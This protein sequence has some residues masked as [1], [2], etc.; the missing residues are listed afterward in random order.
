M[1]LMLLFFYPSIVGNIQLPLI[2]S[3]NLFFWIQIYDLDSMILLIVTTE[4]LYTE[5]DSSLY[6]INYPPLRIFVSFYS[7]NKKNL[8]ASS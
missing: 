3:K 8:S 4:L 1:L 7:S 6:F 2:S 5:Q